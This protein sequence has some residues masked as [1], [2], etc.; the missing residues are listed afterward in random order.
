[1][2]WKPFYQDLLEIVQSVVTEDPHILCDKISA[3][4]PKTFVPYCR[5]TGIDAELLKE[6]E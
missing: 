2:I 3:I 1:M 4:D 5:G 6:Y